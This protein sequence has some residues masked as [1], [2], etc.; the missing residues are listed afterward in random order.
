MRTEDD[1][2]VSSATGHV[3][4]PLAHLHRRGFGPQAAASSTRLG[5]RDPREIRTGCAGL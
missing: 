3:T 5:Q 2:A 1:E 4:L